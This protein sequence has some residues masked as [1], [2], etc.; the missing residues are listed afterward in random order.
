[1]FPKHPTN[2]IP[3]IL[4]YIDDKYRETHPNILKKVADEK[5][6][7]VKALRIAEQNELLYSFS[8]KAVKDEKIFPTKLLQTII[9]EEEEKHS[10]F[11]NTLSFVSS[12]FNDEGLDYMFIKLYKGVPY[13]PRD[14]D[15]LIKK[16]E[17]HRV[18]YAFRK[19]NAVVRAFDGAEIN[20]EKKG[21]LK[22]DLYN[23]FYYFSRVFLDEDFLWRNSRKVKICGVECPIPSYEADFASL[24]IHSLLGHRHMS[25]LDFLYAKTLLIDGHLHIDE[26]LQQTESKKWDYAFSRI[27][28]LIREV[29]KRL[30][31]SGESVDFPLVFSPSFTLKC[32]QMDSKA[33]FSFVLS[34]L[35]DRALYEYRILQRSVPIKISQEIESFTLRSIRK[36]KHWVGDRKGID[37]V[38]NG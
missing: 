8:K 37:T 36:V 27:T 34:T 11:R 29:Y 14:V 2:T 15:V 1:M 20:C 17:N 32:F 30:Y 33:K 24:L 21:L 28:S 25:L 35:L 9:K 16:D 13:T 6:T 7:W 10:R 18:M 4:Y 19:R 12:L 26:I 5:T 23:G 38:R 22:I 31:V 3:L